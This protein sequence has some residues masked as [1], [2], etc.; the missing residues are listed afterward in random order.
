ML[1]RMMATE[2]GRGR[3]C[4]RARLPRRIV[5][6][7]QTKSQVINIATNYSI[8]LSGLDSLA[9]PAACPG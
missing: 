7:G 4:E 2:S 3:E 5:Y 8:W 9:G 6:N 1:V